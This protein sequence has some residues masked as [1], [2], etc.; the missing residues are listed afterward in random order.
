MRKGNMVCNFETSH[1]VKLDQVVSNHKRDGKEISQIKTCSTTFVAHDDLHLN[2]TK[3][4]K[5]TF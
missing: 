1:A 2:G 4:K 5:A 3:A